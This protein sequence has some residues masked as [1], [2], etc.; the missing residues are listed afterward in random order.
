LKISEVAQK[1]DYFFYSEKNYALPNFAPIG[2]FLSSTHPVT[3][4]ALIWLLRFW[5]KFH[6]FFGASL[7]QQDAAPFILWNKNWSHFFSITNDLSGDRRAGNEKSLTEIVRAKKPLT[8]SVS[9]M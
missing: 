7:S 2:R 9:Y 3:L 5:S 4:L 6:F 8:V 1:T